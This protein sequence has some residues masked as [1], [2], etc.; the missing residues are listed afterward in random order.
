RRSRCGAALGRARGQGRHHRRPGAG[1]GWVVAARA[2]PVAPVP[3][4]DDCRRLRKRSLHWRGDINQR[5]VSQRGAACT[6]GRSG[7]DCLALWEMT[8][9]LKIAG[10][11][12][13]GA[14]MLAATNTGASAQKKT[15]VILGTATPGGGFPLYGGAAA[16]TINATDPTLHVEPRNTKGSAENIP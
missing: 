13:L 5:I 14:L 11:A 2:V 7:F 15:T 4:Q 6:L 16:E 9:M 10:L 8:F 1:T 3:M 12:I